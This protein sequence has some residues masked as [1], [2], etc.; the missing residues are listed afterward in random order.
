MINTTD[1]LIVRVSRADE[2][3][4]LLAESI[5]F[6]VTVMHKRMSGWEHPNRVVE[7][8]LG[9]QNWLPCVQF[10]EAFCI[11]CMKFSQNDSR[12]ARWRDAAI[13]LKNYLSNLDVPASSLF[14]MRAGVKLFVVGAWSRG[15]LLLPSVFGAGSHFKYHLFDNELL[16]WL[17]SFS[18]APSGDR[19]LRTTARRLRFYGPRVLFATSWTRP[20]DVSLTELSQLQQ[21]ERRYETAMS[22]MAVGAG[23]QMPYSLFASFLLRDFPTRVTYSAKD[24]ASYSFWSH[25]GQVTCTHFKSSA[26]V[27]AALDGEGEIRR[28]QSL[29]RSAKRRTE[30]GQPDSPTSESRDR[31]DLI[32][33]AFA[34]LRLESFESSASWRT[35]DV[36]V[37]SGREHVD[38]SRIAPK[39]I[40]TFRSYVAYRTNVKEYRSALHERSL[41]VFGHYLFYYLPWWREIAKTPKVDVP[42]CPREFTRVAFVSRNL[43][44][45]LDDFPRTLKDMLALKRKSKDSLG[46]VMRHIAGYFEFVAAQYGDDEAIAGTQFRNP[47]VAALDVPRSRKRVQT[48]K[49]VIPKHLYGWLLFYCYQIEAFGMHLQDLALSGDDRIDKHVFGRSRVLRCADFGF[50]GKVTWRGRSAPLEVVPQIFTLAVR[51]MFAEVS[52]TKTRAVLMPHL[53]SLRVLLV[54]LETGLRCQSIQW[55]DRR[56]WNVDSE[57]ES[58]TKE[59]RPVLVNTDKTQAKPWVTYVVWRAHEVLKREHVFQAKFADYDQHEEVDYE[60]LGNTP[61]DRILPLFRSHCS[62]NPISDQN[63]LDVWR[64]LIIWFQDFYQ[65]LTGET[66][67]SLYR[68]NARRERNGEGTVFTRGTYPPL[69]YCSISVSPIHTPHACR[70]SFATNR[71]GVLELVDLQ[72]LLG[73]QSDVVTAYYIK[74]PWDEVKRRLQDAD[75]ALLGGDSWG[76][77][78]RVRADDPNGAL[79]RSFGADRQRTI[80]RFRV[81]PGVA[82]WSTGDSSGDATVDQS[83]M[84]LLRD[85]PM[86]RIRFRETHICPVGE[87]CPAEVVEKIGEPKRCGVC[88][89]AMKCVDH[90][91]AIAAKRNLLMERIRYQHLARERMAAAGEPMAVLDAVWEKLELDVNELLGWQFSERLLAERME[92][93]P[94]SEE[95][96]LHVGDPEM[97]RRHLRLVSRPCASTRFVLQ[98]IVDSDAYPSMATPQVQAAASRLKHLLLAGQGQAGSDSFFAESD[99]VRDVAAMLTTMVTVNGLSLSDVASRLDVTPAKKHILSL[100][101]E[102][103]GDV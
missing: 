25:S 49:E 51:E 22:A 92:A 7:R 65:N 63:Y 40:N 73:H 52:A 100:I 12:S 2:L 39:W 43:E 86:S 45:S 93:Q 83:G 66:Q 10:D 82:L 88:P 38:L 81:I 76:S 79:V 29:A 77:A 87:E 5:R 35:N 24:V 28:R 32:A 33:A 97:V 67:V 4:S 44:E 37:Y 60:G 102:S 72:R 68:M 23:H 13:N 26:Q 41:D 71:Y 85:G 18:D 94:S 55:L 19:G 11:A 103:G 84:Q 70:A 57:S 8:V 17:T 16:R 89:L 6:A 61:F 3:H 1:C 99:D 91:P 27:L 47:L 21:A 46:H 96:E 42:T 30:T 9:E 36:P 14:A 53:T 59:V 54:A 31:F 95:L 69:R 34:S 74:L 90:L 20:E 75:D 48:S 50:T 64:D 80:E 58:A 101:R 15:A 56:S 62:S 98:R 78:A